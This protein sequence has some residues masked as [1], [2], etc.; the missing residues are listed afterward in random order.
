ME[1]GLVIL[2][3][4]GM[5]VVYAESRTSWTPI[6][7]AG[8]ILLWL[9]V[10]AL[11]SDGN[12]LVAW[13]VIGGAC[14]AFLFGIATNRTD[15]QRASETREK[16]FRNIDEMAKNPTEPNVIAGEKNER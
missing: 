13:S 16:F 6:P 2:C 9:P 15:S 7:F 14:L 12:Q 8:G 5:C 3:F 1:V 10:F 4:M 11:F